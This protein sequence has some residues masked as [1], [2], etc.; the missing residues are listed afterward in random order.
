M[1]DGIAN[2]ENNVEIEEELKETKTDKKNSRKFLLKGERQISPEQAFEVLKPYLDNIR[3][4]VAVDP[5]YAGKW[6][7]NVNVYAVASALKEHELRTIIRLKETLSDNTSSALSWL[8]WL[9]PLGIVVLLFAVAI[10]I[11]S[12]GS[13]PAPPSGP[14]TGYNI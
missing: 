9:I 4:M 12:H 10:N 7:D 14:H 1:N 2:K 13:V 3:F 11:A 5:V 8:K 6:V